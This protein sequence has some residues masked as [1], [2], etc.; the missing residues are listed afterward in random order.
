MAMA[1]AGLTFH[2]GGDEGDIGGGDGGG[3]SG[4]SGGDGGRRRRRRRRPEGRLESAEWTPEVQWTPE[5]RLVF[6]VYR[7]GDEPPSPRPTRDHSSEREVGIAAED[8]A[9]EATNGAVPPK[10]SAVGRSQDARTLVTRAALATRPLVEVPAHLR[11]KL[12]KHGE[13]SSTIRTW[14]QLEAQARAESKE[15][16]SRGTSLCDCKNT[17]GLQNRIDTKPVQPPARL[18]LQQCCFRWPWKKKK[19]VFWGCLMWEF[20]DWGNDQ[21]QLTDKVDV[22]TAT[23]NYLT[24]LG[25][26]AALVLTMQLEMMGHPGSGGIQHEHFLTAYTMTWAVACFVTLVS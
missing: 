19:A 1:M 17:H 10:K 26:L 18:Y 2:N 21:A 13:S 8:S 16:P 23:I 5:G 4:G 25:V 24:H 22:R 11:T 6:G 15:L 12:C 14:L 9:K 20:L 7:R 3:S